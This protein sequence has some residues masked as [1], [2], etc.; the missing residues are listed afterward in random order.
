MIKFLATTHK[1]LLL[2]RR[3]RSGLLVLFVMPAILVLVISLVQNN[4]MKTLGESPTDILFIDEDQKLVG[5]RM[6]KML[7]KA[8]GVTLVKE[9][10]GH[11]LEKAAAINAATKGKFQLCLVIPKGITAAVKKNAHR[12]ALKALSLASNDTT[13]L[14]ASEIE[15]YFDPTIMGGVRSGIN[16]L[17]QLMMVQIEVEEKIA[18]LTELMPEKIKTDLTSIIGT[19]AMQTF[20][21]HSIKPDLKWSTEPLLKIRDESA[22]A[23]IPSAVQQNVPAWSLFGI[24]FIVLPMAGSFI[25]ERLCGAQYRMLSL[26]VSYITI[27][28]G[29]VCAYMI[30][31]LIQI[32]LILCIGKWLL[33]LLGTSAFEIGT[34][35]GAA[36]LLAISAIFAATAY[37]ILLGTV[38]QSYEQASMFGPISVVLAAAIGGI[39]VPVY[40]MPGFMQKI[41]VISPLSWA[42]NGFLE[43]FVRGGNVQSVLGNVFCLFV[44]ALACLV[45]SW[46]VFNQRGSK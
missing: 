29:K 46:I 16:H 41:S 6:E 20:P 34:S 7:S 22:S 5:Q 33:P 45:V 25:K 37:G 9:L 38:V 39:M 3:D 12:S 21:I 4:L 27:V 2:L 24:F 26:P 35:P 14:L 15:V 43:I 23:K 19:T 28:A 1:E 11:R 42:Q 17:L 31:C 18:A 32:A 44:F 40:A 30:I 13:A 36:L 10:N 8:D